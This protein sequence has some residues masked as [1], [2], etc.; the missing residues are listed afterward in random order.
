M[1]SL[2]RN[3]VTNKPHYR[4]YVINKLP[5]LK[6]LDFQRIKQRVSTKIDY[7]PMNFFLRFHWLRAH[8]VT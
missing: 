6:V 1:H 4:L 7:H 2:L 3:P 8:H 5:Q